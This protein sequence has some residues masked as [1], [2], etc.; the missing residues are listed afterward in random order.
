VEDSPVHLA[1]K[2]VHLL[3]RAAM[4]SLRKKKVFALALSGGTTPRAMH[5]LLAE[6]PLLSEIPWD[7]I[8]LFWVD[9]RCVS[10]EDPA[11]NYGTALG[12]FLDRV[13]IPDEHIHPMPGEVAPEEGAFMY[14]DELIRSFG[15]QN[16]QL[17][18]LDLVFLGV[19]TDGHIAS[20]FPGDPALEEKERLVVAVRGGEPN[21]NRLTLTLPVLN[22]SRQIVFLVSGMNKAGIMRSLFEGRDSRLPAQM[23]HPMN[24]RLTWLLDRD[25]ASLLKVKMRHE[26]SER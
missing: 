23:I 7:G 4:A 17:P 25:A 20:L 10:A 24:G 19:G 3:I 15:P 1:D 9:E 13:P 12:D 16:G 5:R 18:T 11:S 26:I 2:A 6:E 8:H 14:Q 21:V 22:R